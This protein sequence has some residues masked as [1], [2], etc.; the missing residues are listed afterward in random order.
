[1]AMR[2]TLAERVSGR[3]VAHHR[4]IVWLVLTAC[5]V[6]QAFV[7]WVAA[8][9]RQGAQPIL[10][11]EPFTNVGGVVVTAGYASVFALLV[12]RL[13]R[14]SVGWLFGVVAV[15]ASVGNATWAYVIYATETIP[16]RLPIPDAA[17]L[18]GAATVTFGSMIIVVLALVFPDGRLL[19]RSW[20][21]VVL[22]ALA[23]AGASTLALVLGSAAMP[24]YAVPSPIRLPDPV[25]SLLGTALPVLLV[26]QVLLY[27]PAIWSLVLRYRGADDIGRLQ[28][29]WLVYAMSVFAVVGAI[30]VLSSGFAYQPG[31]SVGGLIWLGFCVAATLIPVAAAV[32]I[33][34]Y[35]L[36]DIE[37][38]IGRTLVY[39]GLTAILAGMYTA[40][41]RLFNWLF[42]QMTGEDSDVAL[43]LTTL[44]LATTFT[45]IKTWLEARVAARK[46]VIADPAAAAPAA[47]PSVDVDQDE[48]VAERAAAIVLARLADAEQARGRPAASPEPRPATLE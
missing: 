28:L 47:P 41:I 17:A 48:R 31:S 29:K 27:V 36:Y 35:H 14:N 24:L 6:L 38:I 7:L 1:V 42:V 25:G 12:A 10:V 4:P 21:A 5:V 39:G 9:A 11:Q 30:F 2:P 3:L 22:V 45:P 13:P 23:V 8:V 46:G 15:V 43:V 19:S 34:R 32:A 20:R 44:I 26:A 40:G 37:T 33:L 18:L 16:P